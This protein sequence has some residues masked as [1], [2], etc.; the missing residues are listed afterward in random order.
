MQVLVS[1]WILEVVLGR[2]SIAYLL[3]LN[4]S[5]L[6]GIDTF[7]EIKSSI[8]IQALKLSLG[9]LNRVVD[10]FHNL[11]RGFLC[12]GRVDAGSLGNG[13]HIQD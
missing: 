5:R 1:S 13:N 8:W 6:F 11:P 4:S 12:S 7:F 3:L 10:S 2:K 9:P